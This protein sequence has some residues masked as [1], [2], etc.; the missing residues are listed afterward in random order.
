M[1]VLARKVDEAIRIGGPAE[2]TLLGAGNGNARLGIEATP[3][4][5]I[6]RS[7]LEPT[8]SDSLPTV[9]AGPGQDYGGP[10]HE[11]VQW[12]LNR[13]AETATDHRDKEALSILERAL[14]G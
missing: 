14:G 1:L 11:Q 12:A 8:S 3:D 9:Q 10:S 2:I 6:L 4:V 5:P 13:Y 7:E